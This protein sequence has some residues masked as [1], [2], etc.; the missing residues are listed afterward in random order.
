MF[1]VFGV[2]MHD[3]GTILYIVHACQNSSVHNQQQLVRI[4]V[5]H[6]GGALSNKNIFSYSFSHSNCQNTIC[7]VS[8]PV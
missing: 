6:G 8:D 7:R 2:N 5:Y 4:A 3:E 1:K